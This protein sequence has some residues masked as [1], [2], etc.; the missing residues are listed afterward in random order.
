MSRIQ[1]QPR[2]SREHSHSEAAPDSTTLPS[3]DNYPERSAEFRTFVMARIL[4]A[5]AILTWAGIEVRI[6]R[7][8]LLDLR[9]PV[10]SHRQSWRIEF[11][12]LQHPDASVDGICCISIV[13]LRNLH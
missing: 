10:Y 13:V 9:Y 11:M 12:Q 3:A 7:I 2:R 4:M 5:L 1:V 8:F 6:P